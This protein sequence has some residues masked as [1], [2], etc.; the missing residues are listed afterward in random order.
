VRLGSLNSTRTF[1]DARDAIRAYYLLSL[2]LE[3]GIIKSG[4]VFNIAGEEAFKLT[5]VV[6]IFLEMSTNKNIQV[7]IS[8]D[9]LRPID[10]DYQMFDNAKIKATI[11]WSPEIDAREMFKDLL[12]HWR[13]E[14]SMGK[15]PL[16][17]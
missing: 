10:A 5:E 16:N 14:I 9:R 7:E 12:D 4:E 1:Q 17:R 2:E 11:D 6:E 3:K 13:K 15:V 8:E